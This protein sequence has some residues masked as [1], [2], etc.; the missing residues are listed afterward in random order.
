MTG[1]PTLSLSGERLA[2]VYRLAC[3]PAEVGARARAICVEQTVEFPADLVDDPAIQAQIIGEV[4][5]IEPIAPGRFEV[6]IRYPVEAAGREL[7]Q[8]VNLLFGNV[9]LQPGVRLQGFTLPGSLLRHYR[10]PRFGTPGLRDLVGVQDRPLLCTALKPM[11]RS[12]EQLAALAYRLAL[13]GIDLIKDDHGLADQSFCPFAERV[14]CCTEAVAQANRET[15]S[16]S[17]YLP[18]ITAPTDEIAGRARRAKAAGAGG[19][20]VC[21]GLIGFDGVRALADDEA[22]A[23]PIL[24]HPAFQGGYCV[25]PDA[26]L[27]H[28]VLFGQL[29]R[30]TGADAAIFPHWGGRFAFTQAECRDLVAGATCSMG[31]IRPI[32]PVPAGGLRLERVTELCDFYGRDCILL[33]GGDLHAQGADLVTTCRRFVTLAQANGAAG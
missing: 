22:L 29:N 30:L 24:S 19:L 14:A 26:G 18:N 13:G 4:A 31:A 25:N 1:D 8:L 21:P 10:G 23:L 20:L 12:P 27:G 2:A 7:T 11:G 5:S 9:S 6:V 16:R 15:G 3:G 33:I 28:G 32:L 17:L